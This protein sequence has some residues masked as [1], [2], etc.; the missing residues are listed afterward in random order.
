M[1]MDV[2]WGMAMQKKQQLWS[3]GYESGKNK[4]TVYR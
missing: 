3:L 2:E 4:L 1:G